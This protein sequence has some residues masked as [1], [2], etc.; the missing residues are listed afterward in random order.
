MGVGVPIGDAF[1]MS[2][3][4]ACGKSAGFAVLAGTNVAVLAAVD[5]GARVALNTVGASG[6][7]GCVSPPAQA[8]TVIART[9]KHD[10]R[11]SFNVEIPLIS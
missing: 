11:I 9:K 3:G 10:S 8:A 2:V 5:S 7:G 4:G 6:A 1:G